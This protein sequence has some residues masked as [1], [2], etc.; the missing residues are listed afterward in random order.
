VELPWEYTT[1]I[2]DEEE[3][4]HNAQTY[5]DIVFQRQGQPIGKITDEERAREEAQNK[6]EEET[7]GGSSPISMFVHTW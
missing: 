4:H 2:L 5:V 7:I 3:V 1:E 6:V